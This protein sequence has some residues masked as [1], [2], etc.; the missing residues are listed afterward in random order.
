M[1]KR[2]PQGIPGV[3]LIHVYEQAVVRIPDAEENLT[4]TLTIRD[5][6]RTLNRSPF[7]RIESMA[8]M[9]DGS[10]K[11]EELSRS[12]HRLRLSL[13]SEKSKT[14]PLSQHPVN[15]QMKC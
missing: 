13:R 9:C 11:G 14:L 3:S 5:R 10:P 12:L 2:C 15:K 1:Q 4:I 7:N 8:K 6:V